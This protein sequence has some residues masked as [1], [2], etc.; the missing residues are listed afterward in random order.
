MSLPSTD[1]L[2]TGNRLSA[3]TLA[4]TK[5][6]MKPSRAPCSFSNRSLYFARSA[7]T[8]PRST[9]L[10]VVSIAAVDCACTRRSA[11]R[12]RSRVIGT[13]RS[14][15]TSPVR[16]GEVAR[17]AGEGVP[18]APGEGPKLGFGFSLSAR[19]VSTSPLVMRPSRP[20]P[21]M[22]DGSSLCS[23]T[24]RRT[25]GASLS[26]GTFTS[27]ETSPAF[28]GDGVAAAPSSMVASSWP[29]VTVAPFSTFSSRST[30]VAGAGT[31][32]TTLSV[33]RSTRFSS[34][35]TLSPG[36]LRQATSVASATD[37]GS[38]G[39]RT[40][41]VLMASSCCWRWR[42]GDSSSAPIVLAWRRSAPPRRARAAP[43]HAAAGCRWPA[44][45]PD[46]DPSTAAPGA[47]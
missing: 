36:C 35:L 32:S 41:I 45:P 8:A 21:P 22:V 47:P 1:A 16:A 33:S 23:S 42:A 15:L 17:S 2:T 5:N 6:D 14:P 46:D 12:A 4:L 28:A 27:R 34:R 40:S 31:S 38:C 20:E 43:P 24:R 26:P 11:M 39:T 37:S 18:V 13:R 3:S 7:L 30:P 19:C 9:S 25:D 29:P 10:N 44:R